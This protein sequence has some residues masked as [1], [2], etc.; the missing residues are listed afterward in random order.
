MR[1]SDIAPGSRRGR[2]SDQDFGLNTNLRSLSNEDEE[3]VEVT[4]PDEAN[5]STDGEV[6]CS[7]PFEGG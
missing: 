7:L 4:D 3:A 5:D 2:D 1:N 6:L